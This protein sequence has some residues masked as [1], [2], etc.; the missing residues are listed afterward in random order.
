[1]TETRRWRLTKTWI[2]DPARDAVLG[3]VRF[4]SLTGRKLRLYVLVDPAPGDDGNDDRGSR[5]GHG[6]GACD[7]TV[8]SV[9]ATDPKLGRQTSGYA[10]TASDPWTDLRRD[11]DLDRS[12]EARQPGNVVQAARTRLTGTRRR[13]SMTLAIGFGPATAAASQTARAALETGFGR[14]A[15]AYAA[16]WA[17]Y[18]GSV[19]EPRGASGAA[20]SSGASTT[21][22]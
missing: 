9:V 14:A 7:D 10:G 2:G 11:G 5:A 8:A 13:D 15:K 21:S 20:P 16:G 17:G 4:R 6:L 12:Y 18:L 22:P 3:K 19:N 1:M